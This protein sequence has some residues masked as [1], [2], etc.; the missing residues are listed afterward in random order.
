MP[1]YQIAN[2]DFHDHTLL[3]FHDGNR[4]YVAAKPICEIL[5]ITWQGQLTKLKSDPVFATCITIIVTQVDDQRREMVAIA[6][7]MLQAWLFSINPNKV[8]EELR[9]PLN[10]F[11]AES[12]KVL[13]DY[14]NKGIAI[15]PRFAHA[16][17]ASV[18]SGAMAIL[19]LHRGL[20]ESKDRQE[21]A[22]LIGVLEKCYRALDLEPPI[23]DQV[24]YALPS[25]IE[26]C[27]RFFDLIADLEAKGIEVNHH[28]MPSR[29]AISWKELEALAHE[30]SF[31]F[32]MGKA[33]RDRLRLHPRFI[34]DCVVNSRDGKSRHCWVFDQGH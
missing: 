28:R 16:D 23:L 12:A 6:V 31:E 25:V 3:S 19:K 10:R 11:R 20:R 9:E 22:G 2:V 30:H 24:G 13:S 1:N 26:G 14:W 29:L 21:R 7:E 18:F 5:G 34:D 32:D 17:A 15:N 8:K 4:A 27:Q 33:M